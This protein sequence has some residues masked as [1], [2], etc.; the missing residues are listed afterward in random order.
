MNTNNTEVNSENIDKKWKETSMKK[1][2]NLVIVLA[3][4]AA[5][6]FVNGTTLYAVQQTSITN[7]FTTGI[8]DIGIKKLM[9][10]ERERV[11]YE[12]PEDILP[13]EKISMIPVIENYGNSCYVRAEI[14]FTAPGME[15]E[16][17][18]SIYGISED[19]IKAKDG[20]YYYKNILKRTDK[21]DICAGIAIPVNMPQ[22]FKG[23]QIEW[24]I[25]V[26][27]IQSQNFE[28][29]F[30][31][32]SP[33][34]LVEILTAKENAGGVDIYTEAAKTSFTIEYQGKSKEMIVNANDFFINFP[35]LMPGDT[36]SDYVVLKNSTGKTAT[37]YFRSEI[38]HESPLLDK[39]LLKITKV[40]GGKESVIYEGTIRAEG[41][42]NNVLLDNIEAGSSTEMHF[43]ITV[44]ES[45][46]NEFS[47]LTG[48]VKWI[49]STDQIS[50]VKTGDL[51]QTEMYLIL[52]S[53]MFAFL[54]LLIYKKENSD[55][56]VGEN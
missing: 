23:E 9:M 11:S 52:A 12:A 43:M 26:D 47:V 15:E 24:N 8:V 2:K 46:N 38:E 36:F 18:A 22:E 51:Y 56:K 53:A 13:G 19:W 45:L 39:I 28:P 16:L 55:E 10:H 27:A 7:N 50:S 32:D 41:L 35:T 5:L 17:E 54:A 49:F 21:T 25:S 34:G 37:M 48:D 44:P 33:W 31:K 6:L 1:R 3:C 29:D 20:F 40:S 30:T 42:K 4:I 14:T